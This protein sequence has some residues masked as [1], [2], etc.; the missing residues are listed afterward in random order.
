[1]TAIKVSQDA[2]LMP[3]AMLSATNLSKQKLNALQVLM[4][5]HNAKIALEPTVTAQWR[6]ARQDKLQVIAEIQAHMQNAT[7]PMIHAFHAN[8]EMIQTAAIL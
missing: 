7:T 5:R 1:M 2:T 3:I 4:E 6:T 8:L